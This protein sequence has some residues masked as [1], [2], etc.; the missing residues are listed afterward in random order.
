MTQYEV[1]EVSEPLEAGIKGLIARL[2]KQDLVV[3]VVALAAS[4]SVPQT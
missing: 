2:H 3:R 4:V 1:G